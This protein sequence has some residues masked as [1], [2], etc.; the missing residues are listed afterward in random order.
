MKTLLAPRKTIT[1]TSAS[2][3]SL[4]V[5]VA[6]GGSA[7]AATDIQAP[8][9]ET[10]RSEQAFKAF[11]ERDTTDSPAVQPAD[12]SETLGAGPLA[13]RH[14]KESPPKPDE[15]VTADDADVTDSAV[16]ELTTRLPGVSVNDLP[17]FRKHMYRTD[18]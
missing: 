9:P 8:C 3:P 12:A 17:G 10:A 14:E 11:L 16:P 7:L 4:L 2:L 18:I 6:L 1:R 13:E 15:A 5:L